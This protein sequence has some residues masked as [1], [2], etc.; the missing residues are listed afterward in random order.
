MRPASR[1]GFPLALLAAAALGFFTP[2]VLAAESAAKEKLPSATEILQRYAKAIGGEEAFMKHKS[3]HSK[4]SVQM[5]A[6]GL[7]GKMDVYAMRPNKLLI[8]MNLAGIGELNTAYDGT[9]GWLHSALTGAMLLEGKMLEQVAAQADFDQSLHRPQDYKT[10]EVLG[11]EE[12]NGEECYKLKL[13]H[14]T[15]FES[16]EYF[17]KKDGLQKGFTATQESPLGAITATTVVSEYKKFGDLFLPS[18][19]SQKAA[20]IETVMTIDTIE[21]DKVDP[22]MFEP[23]AE[24][25]AKLENDK[26]EEPVEKKQSDK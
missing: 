13:A 1:F 12:F 23:P 20:G 16:T 3:Q 6:Q 19:V 2:A 14:K 18:K 4:G 11:V 24:V 9:N 25:K 17:S 7:T 8:K 26:T 15:G 5:Q 22:S 21:F 10:M